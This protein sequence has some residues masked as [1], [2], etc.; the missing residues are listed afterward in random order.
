MKKIVVRSI[1]IPWEIY[2]GMFE[3]YVE[4]KRKVHIPRDY[5]TEKGHKLGKW[6]FYQRALYKRGK[7]SRERQEKFE[8]LP[9]WTWK[10]SENLWM[11][12]FNLLSQF[13]QREGHTKV[14]VKYVTDDGQKLGNWIAYQR[15]L[16]KRG[17]LTKTRRRLLERLP[18]WTWDKREEIWLEGYNHLRKY[19]ERE[20]HTR[21][22]VKYITGDG[23]KLGQWIKYQRA[24]YKKGKLLLERQKLLQ[25]VPNWVWNHSEELWQ[26]GFNNLCKYVETE[27]HVKVPVKYITVDN[28]NLGTWVSSQH[29][30]YRKGKLSKE[31][32]TAIEK[33][34]GWEWKK[35]GRRESSRVAHRQEWT[36][37]FIERL[38]EYAEREGHTNV[39]ETYFTKDNYGLGK[40]VRSMRADYSLGII[41]EERK[42]AL[43]QIMGWV[44]HIPKKSKGKYP[45]YQSKWLDGFKYLCKYAKREGH[46]RVPAKYITEDGYRLGQWVQKHRQ[47][48]RNKRLSIKSIEALEK[49]NGWV[50]RVR[51]KKITFNKKSS[52]TYYKHVWKEGYEHLVK[53]IE[54]E[55]HTEVPSKY[56]TKDGFKLGN[57]VS[58]QRCMFR[59]GIL[60]EQRQKNLEKIPEWVWSIH[61]EAWIKGF[62]YLCK[63]E[64]LKGNANVPCKYVNEDGFKL[65]LWVM[66]QRQ[67][68]KQGKLSKE[69]KLALQKLRTWTWNINEQKWEN[70]FIYLKDY[71]HN[72]GSIDIPQLYRTVDGFKLGQWVHENQKQYQNGRLSKERQELLESL[73]GWEWRAIKRRTS[74]KTATG[75]KVVRLSWERKLKYLKEYVKEHGHTY[76]PRESVSESGFNLGRWIVT[77]RYLFKRGALSKDKQQALENITRWTWR[78]VDKNWFKSLEQLKKYAER[79]GHL[80][81]PKKYKTKD[82]FNLGYWVYNQR[83]MKE[84]RAISKTKI[85][86]LEQIPGWVW[87]RNLVSIRWNET[88]QLMK[89]FC[90]KEGHA[91]VH[92]HYKTENGYALGRWVQIQ[93]DIYKKGKLSKKKKELLERLS[94]W[95]WDARKDRDRWP[96]GY[97]YLFEYAKEHGN[98]NVLSNYKTKDG[99]NLGGWI[100]RQR[101]RNRKG[102]LTVERQKKLEKLPDWTWNKSKYRPNWHEH[103]SN[104]IEYTKEYG[105]TNVP[106]KY[107]TKDGFLLGR[108]VSQ[109]RF[110]YK[111]RKLTTERTKDLERLSGGMWHK[112]KSRQDWY[113]SLISLIEYA[114]EHGNT[115]VPYN[116]K[117]KDGFNLGQWVSNQRQ[118]YKKGKLSPERI[119]ALE[120]LNGWLWDARKSKL[121]GPSMPIQAGR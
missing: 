27:G 5:V 84:K 30:S 3:L 40:W 29:Q 103:L 82:G 14:S 59:A 1:S 73:P 86:L 2:F 110:L 53:F 90:E 44:W 18:G 4:R 76:V 48:Y 43:E 32:Q 98:T 60:P 54:Q 96:T 101:A 121:T 92:Q 74:R 87:E 65:G 21:V 99:F 16:Y 22:S 80:D 28:Y 104:L 7:L 58:T 95:V 106:L 47:E 64:K 55:G 69:R 25:Q 31:R 116:Y 33:L 56:I 19:A 120:K 94:G 114:K 38:R 100:A 9:G 50:W 81:V 66:F 6:I 72:N 52:S 108:W 91:R 67:Q 93:R 10:Q 111:K 62:K 61:D 37:S 102:L 118:F 117:T 17:K 88:Y 77:Q 57:W 15:D 89:K 107:K 23:H 71:I 39:P 115:K 11:K 45:H 83:Y 112:C 105:N 46:A 51:E 75:K 85:N 13:A 26:E 97:K 63:F 78:S 42:N 36:D 34:P 119:K 20:G 68:Y 79:E 8:R 35:K 12:S 70:A 49:L 109:Q 41:T 113:E 24:L